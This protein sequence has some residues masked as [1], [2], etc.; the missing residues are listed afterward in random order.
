M[1]EEK[2]PITNSNPHP[3]DAG[4]GNN[5]KP[6]AESKTLTLTQEELDRI[7][8]QRLAR[9]RKKYADYEKLKQA[10]EELQKLKEAQ[11]SEEERL[12]AKLAE[13]ERKAAELELQLQEARLESAKLRIL[14]ELGLPK[15]WAS[16]IFGTT[17]DEIRQDAQEL[18]KL[19]RSAQGVGAPTNPPGGKPPVFTRAQL[20]AMSPDEI[21]ANWD[22]ISRALAEGRIK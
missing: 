3:A 13:Y 17:E 6:Q 21:N 20:A 8:E 7:I 19:L 1:P 15:S 9:E 16:R 14:D 10:A 2:D 5:Q 12:Q 22:A 11:M 4:Q 18:L